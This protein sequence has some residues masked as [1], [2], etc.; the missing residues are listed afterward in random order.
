M[1]GSMLGASKFAITTPESQFL[2]DCYYEGSSAE[3][4]RRARNDLL[5]HSRLAL[6]KISSLAELLESHLANCDSY[7]EIIE[8]IVQAYSTDRGKHGASIW[9]DHTPTNGSYVGRLSALFPDAKFIHIVRDGRAIAGS[10]TPLGW[11]P[12]TPISAADWW[13]KKVSVAAVAEM[14]LGKSRA[15]RVHFEHLVADAEKTLRSVCEFL[16]VNF[17]I[18]MLE[19]AGFHVPDY[20]KAQHA[21]VGS[22]ADKTRVD[23]WKEELTIREIE[24]FEYQCADVLGYFGYETDFG[25]Y[26]MP[27]TWMENRYYSA[28]EAFWSLLNAIRSKYR[29]VAAVA[30]SRT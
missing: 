14:T 22:G 12:N 8:G 23:A 10:I 9:I 28:K 18:E 3:S 27:P 7:R 20:T 13:V 5:G 16:D 1:M 11:G 4:S 26:A 30:R 17:E 21:K 2:A 25:A 19:G 6:W 15:M 29:I 24:L